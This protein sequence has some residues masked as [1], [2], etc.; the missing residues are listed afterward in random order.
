MTKNLK[1]KRKKCMYFFLLGGF[2]CIA[3][4]MTSCSE[5]DHID[6][7]SPVAAYNP[8][9]PVVFTDFTPKEGPMRTKLYI[10]GSNFGTDVSKIKVKVGDKEVKVVGSDGNQIYCVVPQKTTTGQVSVTVCGEDTTNV[11]SYTFGDIFTYNQQVMVSTLLRNVDQ[12]G[13]SSIQDGPFATAGFSNPGFMNWNASTQCLYVTEIGKSIRKIDMANEQVSTLITNSQASFHNLQSFNFNAARDT[14]F[15]IDDN[16]EGSS[17]INK[18]AISYALLSEGYRKAYPYVYGRCGYCVVIHPADNC[19][20]YDTYWN[21]A[22]IKVKGKFDTSSNSY[23][24][25]DLYFMTAFG[26]VSGIGRCYMTIHP[27]GKYMLI[28]MGDRPCV[29]KSMYNFETHE[30]MSPTIFAGDF[31]SSGFTDGVGAT[32]RLNNPCQG[33]FVKNEDYVKA[34]K[35]DVY[36]YYI[37]DRE[38]CCIRKITPEGVV[39]LYAGRGSVSV[40]NNFYGYIDGDLTKDARF[41]QPQGIAYDEATQTFYI[42]ERDNHDIRMITFQ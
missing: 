11:V 28:G 23:V 40:N 42:S 39:S 16:G 36:D 41:N 19:K 13:K 8:S 30:F 12:Y 22:M 15:L 7:D 38:N 9:Q 2:M 35:E 20:F 1:R 5:T 31:N 37:C 4:A 29:L 17:D 33:V 6:I 32:A 34:G 18:V 27:S 3:L 26:T 21:A 25:K 14:L 10:T 24:G